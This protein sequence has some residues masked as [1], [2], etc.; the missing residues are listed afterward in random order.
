MR[1]RE[2]KE[3]NEQMGRNKPYQANHEG[4][5]L[6][7]SFR[8]APATCCYIDTGL[9]ENGSSRKGNRRLLRQMN[10]TGGCTANGVS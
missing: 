2:R 6:L 9:Y 5:G 10:Q 7:S 8:V 4:P 1:L 3:V